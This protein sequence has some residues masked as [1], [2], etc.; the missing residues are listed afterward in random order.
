MD[1]GSVLAADNPVG[2]LLGA[3]FGGSSAEAQ[4]RVEEAKKNAND[5][6]GLVRKKKAQD[7]AQPKEEEKAKKPEEEVAK[8]PEAT[9]GAKRKAEDPAEG[10]ED[11][12]K[13]PKVQAEEAAPTAAES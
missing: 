3:A 4:A 8:A 2:G 12:S 13:K 10:S 9:N 1:V 5:L 7:E 6:T 11:D